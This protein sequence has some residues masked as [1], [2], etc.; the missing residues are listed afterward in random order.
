MMMMMRRRS[1]KM[2][3]SI[4][5]L[6]FSRI[7]SQ[8]LG[9]NLRVPGTPKLVE[10]SNICPNLGGRCELVKLGLD[11]VAATWIKLNLGRC[12]RHFKKTVRW[13]KVGVVKSFVQTTWLVIDCICYI[14]FYSQFES[15]WSLLESV[16][17]YS[18]WILDS[19]SSLL[20][21]TH[22]LASLHRSLGEIIIHRKKMCKLM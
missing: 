16:I 21:C 4:I 14:D 18:I 20:P 3:A 22:I 19:N 9:P 10:G 2:T 6:W 8:L 13:G 11:H 15:I 17:I 5:F 1:K 7:I 12:L